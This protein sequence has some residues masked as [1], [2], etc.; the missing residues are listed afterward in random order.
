MRN[1]NRLANN[2]P[3]SHHEK[4]LFVSV[5]PLRVMPASTELKWRD[6]CDFTRSWTWSAKKNNQTKTS[7]HPIARIQ[8]KYLAPYHPIAKYHFTC[9][10]ASLTLQ[11][12]FLP[13]HIQDVN[14]NSPLYLFDISELGWNSKARLKKKKKVFLIWTS[15]LVQLQPGAKA[16]VDFIS[17]QQ[18]I[19]SLIYPP[20]LVPVI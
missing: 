3:I 6:L 9:Y 12:A 11:L 2:K 16:Q 20:V 10:T 5:M 15:A 14:Y 7:S 13:L 18:P 17:S 19:S 1:H 8:V 4:N